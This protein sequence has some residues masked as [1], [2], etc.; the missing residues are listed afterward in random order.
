[1]SVRQ[2]R[3]E[4]ADVICQALFTKLVAEAGRARGA[5]PRSASAATNERR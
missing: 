3:A 1:M 4:I 5:A 2:R